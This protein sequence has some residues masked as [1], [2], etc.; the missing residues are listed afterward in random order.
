MREIPLLE[1]KCASCGQLFS[2]PSLGDFSYGEVVL[3]T[4]D[5]HHYATADAFGEFARRLTKLIDPSSSTTFWSILASLADP[6]SGQILVHSI[7]CPSCKSSK[8]EYW[9][10]HK[11]GV[12]DVPAATFAV[13]SVLSSES[14]TQ[15]VGKHAH[16][17]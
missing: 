17:A 3:C 11:T 5:G 10:G 14:L 7:H 6:I 9:D 1:A 8:L 12:I 2:H 13:A 4:T 15:I 16:E